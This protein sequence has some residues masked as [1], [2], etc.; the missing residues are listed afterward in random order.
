MRGE[1]PSAS[2]TKPQLRLFACVCSP[3]TPL[4]PPPPLLP[5]PL[6]AEMS[7]LP[8]GIAAA[9]QADIFVGAHGANIANAWLMRPGSSII[10]L[11][12]HEFEESIA[13]NNLAVRNMEVRQGVGG[14]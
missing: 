3:P 12:M 7:G 2:L 6:Q 14:V 9:Q 1:Q 5:L 13:H 8:E 4:P 11:T 10:E